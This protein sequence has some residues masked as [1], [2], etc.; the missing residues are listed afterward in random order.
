MNRPN[1]LF[2]YTDQQRFD[3]LAA[4]I[5]GQPVMPNL[6]SFAAQATVFENAYC[7]QPVCTP[8]RATLVTGLWPH[9]H[10]VVNNNIPLRPDMSTVAEML[11]ADYASGH[12]GKWH[13]GDEIYP[14]HG[15]REWR[16]IDDTYWPFYS[17]GRDPV[18]DR[19]S[20]HHWLIAR[21]VQPWPVDTRNTLVSCPKWHIAPAEQRRQYDENRFSREQITQL[22]E[23]LSKP[24]YLAGEAI[25]F[26]RQHQRDPFALFV[27]FFEP[28]HPLSSPRDNQFDPRAV[29]LPAARDHVPDES[30]PLGAA[31]WHRDQFARGF[32]GTPVA[33]EADL[34]RAIAIYW[35]M[36]AL[37]DTHVGRIL[38]ALHEL[39]LDDNTLVFYTTDHGEMLGAHGMWGKGV[40]YEPSVRVPMMMRLPG[41]RRGERVSRRVSQIDVVPT[42]LDSLGVERSLPGQSLRQAAPRDVFIQWNAAPGATADKAESTRTIIT[43]DGWK[44]TLST[45]GRHELRNLDADPHELTNVFQSEP[46]QVADLCRRLAAWQLQTGDPLASLA[47]NLAH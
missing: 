17:A 46:R 33:S 6:E 21:G 12:F 5:G 31:R 44:L 16:A 45:Q 20:H 4:R 27:N 23:P 15:F 39:G 24:A 41:Q 9:Q 11:P 37:V 34:R 8:S 10:G 7:T 19:S 2:L 1:L 29:S 3:S 38:A 47:R 35:G 32:D 36:C 42:L 18:R 28:H 13:L 40:M 14:Q 25:E 26:L 43:P 30:V 22:P